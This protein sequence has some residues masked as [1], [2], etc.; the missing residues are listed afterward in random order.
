MPGQFHLYQFKA[1]EILILKKQ[2]P[3]GGRLW[4]VERAGAEIALK[5][6]TCGHFMTISR[7]KLEKAVKTVQSNTD[8]NSG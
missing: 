7:Q 4:Q 3:C 6:L 5:C 2:H 1:G 8:Q